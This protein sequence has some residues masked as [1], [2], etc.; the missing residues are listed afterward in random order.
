MLFFSCGN[1]SK[2]TGNGDFIFSN[3]VTADNFEDTT[4]FF[5]TPTFQL[6]ETEYNFGVVIEGEKVSHTYIFKN[7]GKS[8]LLI[9]NIKPSCGCTSP[10]WTKEPIK[11][12]EEGY[13]ELS[14]DS[15]GR[16]GH[17]RKTAIVYANTQPNETEIAFQCDVVNN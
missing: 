6:K 4:L 13:I 5:D 15:G 3:P 10:K 9:S 11:P 1:N 16:V 12:G 17:Q 7:I 8:N 14:F 2:K